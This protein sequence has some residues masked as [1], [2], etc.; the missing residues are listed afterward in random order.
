M[1]IEHNRAEIIHLVRARPFQN[2]ILQMVGGERIM[3][4]HPENIAFDPTPGGNSKFY[5]IG[6]QIRYFG[7]FE[8]I[9]SIATLDSL[10]PSTGTAGSDSAS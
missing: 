4:E 10:M 8:A 6:G 1:N 3:I 5:V 2:F 9:S 7:N